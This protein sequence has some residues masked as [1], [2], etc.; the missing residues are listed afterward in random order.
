MFLVIAKVF[1]QTDI[2]SELLL[3]YINLRNELYPT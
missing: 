1:H 2:N 3:G